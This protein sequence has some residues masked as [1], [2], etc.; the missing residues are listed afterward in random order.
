[1]SYDLKKGLTKTLKNVAVVLTPA[2]LFEI[3]Q[4]IYALVPQEHTVIAQVVLSMVAYFIKN[5]SEN[6]AWTLVKK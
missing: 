3:V 6:G 1:M 5:A 2:I 4:N